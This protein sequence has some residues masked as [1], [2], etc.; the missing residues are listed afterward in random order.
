MRSPLP[1]VLP[2]ALPA[3]LLV[4]ACLLAPAAAHASYQELL[5]D[6]CRDEKVDGTYSQ[7]D[8]REALANLPADTD[9]YTNCRAVLRAAQLAA[10]KNQ[11]AGGSSTP[12]GSD[13]VS[14]ILASGDPLATATPTEKA[15]VTAATQQ[16]GA[17]ITVAGKVV[18][19]SSLGAGR[20][21]AASIS[22]LPVPLLI[23]LAICALAAIAALLAVLI[24]RVRERRHD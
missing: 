6:A 7:K 3:L 5:K 13:P 15:A 9:Q 24:P 2:R 23:A 12:A 17:P 14:Q 8:Y 22:D 10:A 1:T 16:G 19:P 11:A 4:L 21:V 20:T 18:E